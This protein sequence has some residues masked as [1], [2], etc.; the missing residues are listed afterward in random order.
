MNGSAGTCAVHEIRP[1][2]CKAC[3]QRQRSI[4]VRL[5]AC[6]YGE[7]ALSD[8][9]EPDIVCMFHP[10]LAA[11]QPQSIEGTARK[12]TKWAAGGP[13]IRESPHK[14]KL[15]TSSCVKE[16][17]S[18]TTSDQDTG[19]RAAQHQVEQLRPPLAPGRLGSCTAAV[20]GQF[21]WRDEQMP[22]LREAWVSSFPQ[23]ASL[24][25]PLLVTAFSM[26]GVPV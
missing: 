18:T 16:C 17:F 22:S 7:A 26:A 13:S 12:S 11:E 1:Q 25:C 19:H 21:N 2:L 9:H 15:H 24:T 23:I 8:M 10:G 4:L 5:H 3:R 20:G 6:G 14:R